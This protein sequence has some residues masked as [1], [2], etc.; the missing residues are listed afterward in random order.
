MSIDADEIVVAGD[1]GVYVAPVGTAGPTD[2]ATALN[3]SFANLGYTSEDG[4]S[5][6]PGM[7]TTPIN[8]HQ[9]FYAVRHIVTGRSLDIGFELLQWNQESF[10]LAM[11]GGEF[12]TTA[13]PPAYYTYTPPE[14]SD[15]YYRALVVEWTDGGKSYRLH[16]PKV[17]A[18]DVSEVTLARTDASGLALTLSAVATDGSAEYTFIT[19]DPAFA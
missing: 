17:M 2:I 3:A 6:S 1:A 8:T 4:I 14:P 15:I 16:V 11:G 10:M 5:W 18:S 13:G 7:E 9:S 19:N 12:A